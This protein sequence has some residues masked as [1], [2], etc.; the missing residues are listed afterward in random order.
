MERID[1][2]NRVAIAV[3]LQFLRK[4]LIENDFHLSSHA[5]DGLLGKDCR[6]ATRFGEWII[7]NPDLIHQTC[8]RDR[9]IRNEVYNQSAAVG[10]EYSVRSHAERIQRYILL[11]IAEATF[12]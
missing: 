10:A 11:P 8:A 4:E 6:A 5:L 3:P 1:V 7:Y 9:Q 2:A 12:P